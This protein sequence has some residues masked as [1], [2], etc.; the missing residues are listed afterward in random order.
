MSKI[1]TAYDRLEAVWCNLPLLR[2]NGRLQAAPFIAVF[3]IGFVVLAE[4][5]HFLVE[6]FG[7]DLSN[8]HKAAVWSLG[9]MIGGFSLLMTAMVRAARRQADRA[10]RQS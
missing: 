5:M 1:E 4:G 3:M 7:A 2:E 8:K 6:A 10:E 9:F